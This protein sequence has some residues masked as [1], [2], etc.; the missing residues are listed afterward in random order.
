MT[1]A[2]ECA[3]LVDSVDWSATSLGP[4]AGWSP[5]L[6]AMVEG[7][8]HS[9]QPMLL[10]WGR[11][12]IQF[13]N[14][15]FVPSF[16]QGKH[17]AAMGQAARVCWADAWPVIGA[18]IDA[19]MSRGEPAWYADALVPIHRNGRME[20]VFWTYS[21]S[22]AFDGDG[23]IAGTLVIVTEMTGRVVAARR[24]GALSR[25]GAAIAD[26]T[27][28]DAVVD[29]L[30]ATVTVCPP[31]L[32]FVLLEMPGAAPRR[33]GAADGDLAAAAALAAS[34]ARPAELEL[35]APIAAGPWPEPVTRLFAADLPSATPGAR[36]SIGFGLSPRLPFDDAYRSY[37]LQL[38][39]QVAAAIRRIDHAAATRATEEHRDN[40]LMQ[41]PVATAL[42]TG[43]DHVYQLANPRYRALVGRDPTGRSFAAAFPELAG[44]ELPAIFD[45]VYHL[46]EPY[47]A[48][49]QRIRLDLGGGA[50]EDRWFNFHLEPL[51]GADRAV[52]GMMVVA[53][54]VTEQVRSSQ[55]K[56]E[57]LAMLG[58]ELRNPL[59]PIAA[60]IE[61]M[62]GKDSATAR[63]QAT[64]ERQLHHVTRL[65]DD[66]LDVSRITR[67][68]IELRRRPLELRAVV[69]HAIEI[70]RHLVDQRG[71]TLTVDVRDG[72][73]V[74]GDEAR[75]TQV[76]ANL[77]TNA[78]RYTPPG[79]EIRV[80]AGAGDGAVRLHV[81]DTGAGMDAELLDRAF[82][83]FVQ[84]QRGPDRAGGGLGVG[85]AVVKNVVALH[86]GTV[87]ARSD[88]P[89]AGTEVT[90]TLPRCDRPVA[91]AGEPRAGRLPA[92]RSPKRVVIV[93]DN[94][95]AAMLL[96]ELV[97][98]CGHQTAVAYD[99]EGALR[100][101]AE[102]EP[103]VVVLD[104]GLPGMDGY[105]LAARIRE[106]RDRCRLIALT[107]YGQD[108]D[109]ARARQAGFEAHF[110]KPLALTAFL[111]L[112]A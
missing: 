105:E 106:L 65:V 82:D 8:L 40:L 2:S 18:Q 17:P 90:V 63:E 16:G 67:G 86:G 32:P 85:L 52:Y 96:G 6:R 95:D 4:R 56:D 36:A 79:G 10:F 110:V 111:D 42:L 51:R 112:I 97:R 88:G 76:V 109:R 48:T 13:Y 41:A 72:L 75:L 25:L 19:V 20:E 59:A 5:A 103:D 73:V 91:V 101:V 108:S 26:A 45:R 22:P 11:D 12:L 3:A 39:E 60:A 64:I 47:A 81:I 89:G 23:S 80:V 66:L 24:L 77:L 104:I 9:R 37:L 29:A 31:D 35:S 71:H 92:A 49:E 58:H 87:T 21:Y 57:F 55:A 100:V 70:T 94:E 93:D 14:D 83:L 30:E 107:G 34:S 62:K 43:P 28:R 54:D 53:V 44:S 98:S 15:A 38:V 1:T 46:G 68:T 27:S 99:P 33:L 84:G 78:A 69:A 61:L 102:F 50:L 74:D 7:I